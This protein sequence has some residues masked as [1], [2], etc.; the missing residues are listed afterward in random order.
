MYDPPHPGG[1]IR[2]RALAPRELSVTKA[3][4]WLGIGRVALSELL[5]GRA[6]VS[7]EMALRLEAAGWGSAE[8][9]LTMQLAYDLWHAKQEAADRIKKRVKRYPVPRMAS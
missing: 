2:R 7:P 8:M 3:A 5:N 6:G 9:W 4:E 1:L